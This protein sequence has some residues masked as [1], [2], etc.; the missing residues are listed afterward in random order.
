MKKLLT[1]IAISFVCATPLAAQAMTRAEILAEISRLVAVVDTIKAQLRALGVD[2][3]G[4]TTNPTT[5]TYVQPTKCLSWSREMTVDS[6]G[7]DVLQLQRFLVNQQKLDVEPNG[8]FGTKTY[9]ALLNW[10]RAVGLVGTGIVDKASADMINSYCASGKMAPVTSSG[11]TTNPR[12]GIPVTSVDK[13][14]FTIEPKSGQAPHQVSAF[15]AVSG[16]TCTSYALDWGDGTGNV[17]REGGS[18][19]CDT[20]SINRQLTHIYQ[21]RGTYTVTFR[22]IRGYLSSAPIVAQETISVY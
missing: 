7:N 1:I 10:Q 11:V 18:T 19:N 15:F 20:D 14:S 17:S 4:I 8:F 2:V 12:I 22:T 16:T 9:S 3:D 5:P 21:S 6:Q 13:Y